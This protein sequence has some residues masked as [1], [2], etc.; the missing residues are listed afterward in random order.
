MNGIGNTVRWKYTIE[1]VGSPTKD[2]PMTLA[3][4]VRGYDKMTDRWG[5]E[6]RLLGPTLATARQMIR[7]KPDDPSLIDPY[8]LGAAQVAGLGMITVPEAFVYYL[9]AE[10]DPH[11]LAKLRDTVRSTA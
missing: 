2:R 6:H 3:H 9:A 5:M 7:A 8:E 11:T 10:E 4:Y 1:A